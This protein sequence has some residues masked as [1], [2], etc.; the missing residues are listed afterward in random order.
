MPYFTNETIFD[1]R[2]KLDHLIVIGGGPIGLE[3]AQAHLRLGSRVTVLEAHQGAR[4]G[5]S[6]NVA[7]SC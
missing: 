5:R 4:Q 2:D 6:G 3:L 7:R 1:N